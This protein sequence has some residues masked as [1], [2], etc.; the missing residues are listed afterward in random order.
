MS[1]ETACR[2]MSK[3]DSDYPTGVA[4]TSAL[5]SEVIA[6]HPNKKAAINTGQFKWYVNERNSKMRILSFEQSKGVWDTV[7][8]KKSALHY[9]RCM[10]RMHQ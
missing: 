2:S 1:M 6:Y 7:S 10:K 4:F 8:W 9:D 3:N 5:L